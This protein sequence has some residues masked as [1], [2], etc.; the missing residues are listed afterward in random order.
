METYGSILQVEQVEYKTNDSKQIAQCFICH[1]FCFTNA[2]ICMC[3]TKKVSCE[4]HVKEV[5]I[6]S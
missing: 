3:D 5:L 1:S 4:T 6:D 2:I